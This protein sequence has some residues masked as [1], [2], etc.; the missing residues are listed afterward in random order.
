MT[1]D[2][3]MPAGEF[4]ALVKAGLG[5]ETQIGMLQSLSRQ[6]ITALQLFTPDDRREQGL[7]EFAEFMW[8]QAQSA[9]EGSDKQLAAMRS[10]SSIARTP[11]QTEVVAD[12]LDGSRELAGLAVDAD[13]RWTLL[14]R[15]VATGNA[16][17]EAID[18]E[19][20]RDMTASGQRQAAAARA[21]RPT[22]AA[23]EAAWNDILGNADLPNAILSATVGGFNVPDH[24]EL[25]REF[26]DRYFDSLE[27]VWADRTNDTA[28]TIVI[29]LYPSYLV[30]D[31][32]V[33]RTTQFLRDHQVAPAMKRL[34]VEG[35][36]A[37]A[38]SLRARAADTDS[39]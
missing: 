24:A 13:L 5:A 15:L 34:L 16:D 32:V 9:A 29:G 37:V 4:V 7:A 38:R 31:S 26:V 20:D 28:Q 1:R 18:R 36:D 3:E 27:Q 11:E 35:A 8:Q 30:E 23:K 33:E 21:M 12:L 22:S 19:L 17:D 10:F 2:A 25:N 6:A 14:Q 39:R